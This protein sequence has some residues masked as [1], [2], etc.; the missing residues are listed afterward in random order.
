METGPPF[1]SLRD[2]HSCVHFAV[3]H[4]NA[5]LLVGE[6]I[7]LPGMVVSVQ[8]DYYSNEF[9]LRKLEATV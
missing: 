6:N 7:L 2:Q 9:V 4:L 8:T 5:F 1:I 3:S